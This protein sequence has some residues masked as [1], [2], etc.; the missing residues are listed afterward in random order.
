M[1]SMAGS[2]FGSPGE[3]LGQPML[4]WDIH[5][6]GQVENIMPLLCGDI[7]TARSCTM[8]YEC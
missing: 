5:Q 4:A 3:P 8:N 1:A 2:Q 7:K 6:D